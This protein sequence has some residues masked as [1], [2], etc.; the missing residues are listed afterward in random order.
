MPEPIEDSIVVANAFVPTSTSPVLPGSSQLPLSDVQFPGVQ[1]L[2]SDS[3]Q[4]SHDLVSEF[5][6]TDPYHLDFDFLFSASPFTN[7]DLQGSLDH[8]S[9]FGSGDSTLD[10]GSVNTPS[11]RSTYPD[12]LDFTQAD[13]RS[14]HRHLNHAPPKA[15]ESSTAT[16]KST[17]PGT[18]LYLA[19]PEQLADHL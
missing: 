6:N 4:D 8:I 16:Q 3:S 5:G 18:T 19:V 11:L 10:S 12:A 2:H 13:C 17:S 14:G 7:L 15:T 1:A 9:V